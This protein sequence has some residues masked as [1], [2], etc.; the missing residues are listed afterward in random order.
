MSLTVGSCYYC[1]NQAT[2]RKWSK[3]VRVIAVYCDHIDVQYENTTYSFSLNKAG[4]W[5]LGGSD[6][7]LVT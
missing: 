2:G 1:L 5:A 3:P 6:I 7:V 4:Q